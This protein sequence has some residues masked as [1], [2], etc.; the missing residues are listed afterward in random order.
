MKLRILAFLLFSSLLSTAKTDS[1]KIKLNIKNTND[2]KAYL[3]HYYEGKVF[4]V[5]TAIINTEGE[6]IFSKEKK[7]HS[8]LYL[9]YLPSK[10]YFDVFIG[11]DQ[12]FSLSTNALNLYKD[13][14]IDGAE[15]SI[16]FHEYQIFLSAKNKEKKALI[17]KYKKDKSRLRKE[18][19]IIDAEVR[20][21]IKDISKKYAKS[22]LSN[23]L[24]FTLEVEI[25]D[26]DSILDK[27]LKNRKDSIQSLSYFYNKNHYWDYANLADSTILKTPMFKAKID[28][29][30]NKIIIPHPDTVAY[31]AMKLIERS[32]ENK[33][34]FRYL[35]SYSFNYCINSKIMGMDEAFCKIAKRY[36]LSGDAYWVQDSS[37]RKIKERVRKLK[38]N[39][40]GEK[41]R[42]IKL[43]T[44]DGELTSLY[45]TEAAL[46]L[47][48]FWETDCGH[49]KKKI[50]EIKTQILDKF[51]D[52][53]LKVFSVYIQDEKDK[54]SEFIEEHDLFDFINCYDPKNISNYRYFYNIESTPMLYLLDKDKRIIAKKV[55]LKTLTKIIES[56]LKHL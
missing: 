17:S 23:F 1:Y 20:K 48:V 27:E 10:K 39:L 43:Q 54:W 25:P 53:G 29:Y 51:A 26:Y 4:A 6:A 32:R 12:D 50:P 3:A 38:Y 2:S 34:M 24:R 11:K 8:G 40:I 28:K 55:D 35:C 16:G 47:M 56:K 45:E 14:K 52:K 36:Y 7:L 13:I 37:M 19:S 44:I 9:I 33:T 21:Y 15:E 30:Y 41:A 22:S 18:L 31:E 46:T 5:D 49:C 42:D